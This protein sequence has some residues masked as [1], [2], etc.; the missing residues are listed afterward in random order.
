MRSTSG[1]AAPGG[2]GGPH[3][4]RLLFRIVRRAERLFGAV[5]AALEHRDIAVLRPWLRLARSREF[6]RFVRFLA[7]GG[8]NFA[9]SY[10]VFL[11]VHFLGGKPD[12]AVTVSWMLGVLFNFATTGRI[13]FGTGRVRLL[14]R[15]VGV[16][17]VQ[18]GAN[19]VLLRVLLGAG[20]SAPV[21]QAVVVTGLAVATFFAL[22]R[23]VFAPHLIARAT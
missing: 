18:L 20:L 7:T 1:S 5:L 8:V 16:Y 10:T 15:F 22:R 2:P 21:A 3:A 23:F 4:P 9:F 12:A 19:I 11:L 13:V 17:V 6:W 14:P